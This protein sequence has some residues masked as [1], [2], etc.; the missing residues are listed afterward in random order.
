MTCAAP[1]A[2]RNAALGKYLTADN[3]GTVSIVRGATSNSESVAASYEGNLVDAAV[4]ALNMGFAN[5]A[6]SV[7]EGWENND[8]SALVPGVAGVVGTGAVQVL[9]PVDLLNVGNKLVTGRGGE[10][11]PTDWVFAGLDAVALI[12]GFFSAGVGYAGLKGLS[13]LAKGAKYASY[14]GQAI[15]I[16]VA[17]A[18]ELNKGGYWYEKRCWNGRL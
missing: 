14:A 15:G 11:E 1:W 17:V 16:P 4:E 5:S 3:A 6:V 12:A 7:I 18:W 13:T 2:A 9:A 8:V 10:L